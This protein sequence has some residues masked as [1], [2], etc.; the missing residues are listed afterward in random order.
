MLYIEARLMYNCKH[1]VKEGK[2][3]MKDHEME[4]GKIMRK[5]IFWSWKEY[6]VLFLKERI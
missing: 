1:K 4:A 6:E 2:T 5:Y 3:T